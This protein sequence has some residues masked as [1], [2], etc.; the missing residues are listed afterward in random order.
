M[1]QKD[2]VTATSPSAAGQILPFYLAGEDGDSALIRGRLA[3]VGGPASSILARHGYPE[4]VASLQAEALA[5]ASCLS[6][7]MKFDGVFTLQAKGDG[8]VKTLL[9][10]VTSDGALRGYAAFDEENAPSIGDD[11]VAAMT[12]S[13]PAL[14]GTG[15]AA[16]TVDQGTENG[17]Y[18]GIVELAGETL[19]DAAMAW[20]ANSEQVDSHIVAAAGRH[21]DDWVATALMVQRVAADGGKEG[22]ASRAARDDAWTTADMLLRSVT[23]DELV[24]PRL[25]PEDLVF[26]LFNALRP[27]VAPA[28]PVE[29]RCRC[30]PEKVEAVLSR[31]S[32]EE[33]VGLVADSGKVEVTCEFCKT[34]RAVDPGVSRH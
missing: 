20:F 32:P 2:T 27:H 30:S 25:A 6:T 13:V 18:Q 8:F 22:T 34:M 17:R 10:D 19:G 4:P 33:F 23:R 15:Y 31:M 26:R 16:F 5:I 21:G 29:D 11:M 14:L 3:S 24:D 9:A 1:A 28:Q 7:F 12:A